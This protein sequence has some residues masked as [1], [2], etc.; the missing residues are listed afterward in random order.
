MTRICDQNSRDER[1]AHSFKSSAEGTSNLCIL[2]CTYL[3]DRKQKDSTQ[4][5]PWSSF[6]IRLEKPTKMKK[7]TNMYSIG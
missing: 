3:I 4:T 7:I 2:R 6:R 1:A 5:N